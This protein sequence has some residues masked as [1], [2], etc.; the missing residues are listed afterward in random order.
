MMEPA[1]EKVITSEQELRDIMGYPSE[2][3]TRKTINY[4]DEHCQVFIEKSPFIT[5]A[6]SDL[7]G[8]LDVSPKG[9]PAGFVKILS[10]KMLA[11]PDRPGNHKADTLTNIIQNPNIGLIFLIPGIKETLRVNG[12]AKIVTDEKVLELLSCQ[13]KKPGFAII[14]IVKEAFMHCA[15]CIIRSNLWTTV[16]ER[17]ERSI[18]TLGKALVDHGK[19]DISSEELDEMIK[20]DEKTNLY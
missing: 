8:N 5:I 6:T 9:D 13:G 10:D 12:E 20:D 1:F 4:I 19:L 16:D 17:Q 15:K 14:V 11:I 2:I 3:V 7:K 18:A